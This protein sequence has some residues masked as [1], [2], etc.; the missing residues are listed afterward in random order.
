MDKNSFNAGL[1]DFIAASPT[2]FHAVSHMSQVL[3]AA[4][5]QPLDESHA[6]ELNGGG[7]YFVTRN[8]SSIIAFSL[9]VKASVQDAVYPGVRLTGAHTDSP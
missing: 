4:G 8:G 7:R 5:F 1:L 3:L 2:P 6:W 9:P